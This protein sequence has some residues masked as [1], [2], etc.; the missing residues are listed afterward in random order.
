MISN[1]NLYLHVS[2][3]VGLNT[4]KRKLKKIIYVKFKNI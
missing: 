2:C 1:L 3:V 4:E